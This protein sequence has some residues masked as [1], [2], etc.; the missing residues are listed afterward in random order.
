M[1]SSFLALHSCV[2]LAALL[3]AATG[4]GFGV[5]AGPI[6]LLVLNDGSAVQM[7]ILLSLLVSVLF[8][9]SLYRKVDK[10]LLKRLLV[11]TFLGLPLGVYGLLQV[12]VDVLK[13][14]AAIAVLVMA[15]LV[16]GR[17]GSGTG[18][19]GR[20]SHRWRDVGVGVVSGAMS[21]S[22]A[23]PGPVA[24]AHMAVL[25]H[26]KEVIRATALV[27]FAFSYS[28]AIAFQ[29]LVVGVSRDTLSHHRAARAGDP[30]RRVPRPQGR[31]T[32]SRANLSQ[33]HCRGARR[34]RRRPV[35][36]ADRRGARS[37]LSTVRRKTIHPNTVRPHT[38]CPNIA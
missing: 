22:L 15:A 35:A 30:R 9:P 4:I 18:A 13:L 10:K 17:L 8:V 21:V 7:T 34:V 23:M 38:V 31:G 5:I 33:H 32:H 26:T 37:W 29:A 1:E 14:V 6:V 28:A 19:N 2:L 3:Q 16:T 25:N 11:G 24:A 20:I 36:D 27:L 12:S